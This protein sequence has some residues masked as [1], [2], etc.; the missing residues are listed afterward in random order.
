MA[1]QVSVVT[2]ER[3]LF[4]G[5]ANIVIARGVEGEV[6]IQTG[7]APMLLA[8][9]IGTL[10]VREPDGTET[11]AAVHGGFLDVRNDVCTVL[12]DAAELPD[13][14]DVDRARRAEE[15]ARRRLQEV[16][17]AEARAALQR[18]VVRIDIAGV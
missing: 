9:D 14:V 7:H 4:D 6:G 3:V 15:R 11:R 2:P 10:F 13:Q 16:D 1:F 17:D 5:E 8:L 12:A 18:A